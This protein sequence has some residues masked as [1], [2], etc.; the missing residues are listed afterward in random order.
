MPLY[1]D[2]W[3]LEDESHSPFNTNIKWMNEWM[4]T[5][6]T[7]M[8][9]IYP[10]CWTHFWNVWC[11]LGW[12]FVHAIQFRCHLTTNLNQFFFLRCAMHSRYPHNIQ[13]FFY[14]FSFLCSPTTK[15]MN[16]LFFL[17]RLFLSTCILHIYA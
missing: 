5:T 15:R 6:T 13:F 7:T 10:I 11:I 2:D 12:Q 17:V 14:H 16:C 3:R 4:E 8:G 9:V 1:T